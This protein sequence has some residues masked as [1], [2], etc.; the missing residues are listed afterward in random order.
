MYQLDDKFWMAV[1][2]YHE[3]RGEEFSGKVAVCH[4]IAERMRKRKKNAHSIVFER[5][6]FSWVNDNVNDAIRDNY[7][8]L[9]CLQAVEE[10]LNQRMEGKTLFGA[11][12]YY[13]PNKCNPAWANSPEMHK[14]AV[15]GNHIFM[16]DGNYTK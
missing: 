6:Q 8:L 14:V 16:R 7:A 4:V 12:H 9:S 2:C 5:N 10:C 13:N 1:C 11:D 15:I 3:A